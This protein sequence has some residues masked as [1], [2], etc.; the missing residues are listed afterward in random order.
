MMCYTGHR[1]A[2]QRQATPKGQ[3]WNKESSLALRTF[4]WNQAERRHFLWLYKIVLLARI[5]VRPASRSNEQA[6]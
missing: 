4:T 6:Q 2:Q 3:Q 5:V 1:S